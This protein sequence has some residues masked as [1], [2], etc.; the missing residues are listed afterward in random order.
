M[1]TVDIK[2]IAGNAA[3][4]GPSKL[5]ITVGNTYNAEVVRAN[6][7][8]AYTVK[9]AG[10]T[11]E[12]A[13][14]DKL[15]GNIKLKVLSL[16]PQ[17]KV[18]LSSENLFA[19]GDILSVKSLSVQGDV[20][21]L[22]V[23]DKTIQARLNP[24][25]TFVKFFAEVLTNGAILDMKPVGVPTKTLLLGMLA[26]EIGNYNVFDAG[27]VMQEFNGVKIASFVSEEFRRVV[28]DS[29]IFFENKLLKRMSVEG[30]AK[31][32]AY[33]QGDTLAKDTITKT[34]IANA[35]LSGELFTFFEGDGELDFHGGMMRFRR[36]DNG[37][38]GV[39][40]FLEFTNIGRT[41]LSFVENSAGGYNVLIKTEKDINY[42][43]EQL[44]IDNVNI[45]WQ[46]LHENDVKA[47]EVGKSD[48]K[49]FSEFDIRI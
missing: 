25:P 11:I 23:G 42:D 1:L 16:E 31:Y 15:S 37:Y 6:G 49:A 21:T 14:A 44:N 32:D 28:K 22:Q 2:N 39:S 40:M 18:A 24:S 48:F 30:D 33:T 41:F 17:I 12:V 29:G 46:K 8:G 13:T 45:R 27:K 43:I 10:N 19:K 38:I 47:F 4:Q 26:K 3:N 20:Y 7:E 34:Q 5:G 9:M 35:L 36:D